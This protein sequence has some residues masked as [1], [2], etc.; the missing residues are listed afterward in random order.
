MSISIVVPVYNESE[1]IHSFV[2]KITPILKKIEV[3]YEIIFVLDPSLAW[4]EEFY[5]QPSSIKYLLPLNLGL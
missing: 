4:L 5:C 1:N 3:T 2:N